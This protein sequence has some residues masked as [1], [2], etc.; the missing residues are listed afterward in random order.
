MRIRLGRPRL[1]GA[2]AVLTAG[3][4]AWYL[5]PDPGDPRLRAF[6]RARPPVPV[7]F[8]SRSDPASLRA[9]APE[10]EGYTYPG[11]PLWQAREGRLR[12]LTPHGTVRELTWGQVL[13]GGGRI[14][15]VMSPSVSPDG[16]TVYFAG[17]RDDDHGRFRLFRV[18][19]NG[20]GLRQLTGGPDDPGCSAVPPMR[21]AADGSVLPD[22]RRRR[23]DYDDVD[24][25]P[26][27]ADGARL[28]FASS[29]HPD[30]GRGGR[31]RATALW[32]VNVETGAM[33]SYTANRA[34]D[35]WPYPM[36]GGYVAFSLWSR[37]PEVVSADRTE[38]RPLSPGEEGATRPADLWQGAFVQ[39]NGE[40]FGSLVKPD[41]PVWRPRPLFN[42][43]IAFMTTLGDPAAFADGRDVPPPLTVAQAEGG[44]IQGVPS[45][46]PADVPLPAREG[47]G[48]VRGPTADRDGR[49]ISLAT[50]GPCPGGKVV[51]AGAPLEPGEAA[52]PPARYGLYLAADDWGPAGEGSAE[53]IGLT[54][55][56]DDPDLVDAEPV[57]AYARQMR[58][59]SN[60][61]PPA[62]ASAESL[63]LAGGR[64]YHGPV[65]QVFNSGVY[66]ALMP[67]QP[68]QRT[69]A[70]RG[71]V[72]D[73][74]PEK[75]IDHLR[76]YAS[77][78]D[79]FDDPDRPRVEGGWE[80][81]ARAPV[82][83][84]GGVGFTIPTGVPT[85]LAGF[86]KD[87]KVASWTTPAADAAG[88]R[89]T[90]YAYAGDHYSGA[91]P[92]ARH[93]CTGCHP[94]HSGVAAYQHDHAE[95]LR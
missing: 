65:G 52:P 43:R 73:R 48:L 84:D 16:E 44:L 2:V 49:P 47:G 19:L 94:G 72:F 82:R 88:R 18:G 41:V 29:R 95:R 76:V 64:D 21:F 54:L 93:F 57:A 63:R 28:I 27:D 38:L 8:T 25:A 92:G 55:L 86:D 90:F 58:E 69:D 71:P 35:R 66:L 60:P 22:D 59:A 50:P 26:L 83:E 79:R 10:G 40:H 39:N 11:Q 74:P 78:R 24:P 36:F 30:L 61:D 7:I 1:L 33:R 14:I 70:G 23:T 5:W 81:L 12:V 45:A 17:R 89:A 6:V 62:P 46:R 75:S 67:D 56:F 53:R 87:G 20:R 68:G 13:P 91:R 77:Y 15:D 34:N 4:A 3:L 85:V 51:L 32:V 80:L 42:N 9:A 37:V 31:R